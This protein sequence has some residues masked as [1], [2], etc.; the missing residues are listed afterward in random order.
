[1]ELALW[2]FNEQPKIVEQCSISWATVVFPE[3][4]QQ[5]SS[6]DRGGIATNN[7]GYDCYFLAWTCEKRVVDF[8][9]SRDNLVADGQETT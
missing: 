6:C 5:I 4:V 1:M 9:V 2:L 7:P 8:V 3:K